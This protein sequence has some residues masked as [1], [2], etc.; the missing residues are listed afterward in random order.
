MN[1][2]KKMSFLG[3]KH[4]AVF[5][6]SGSHLHQLKHTETQK[7]KTQKK[8]TDDDDTDFRANI[9]GGESQRNCLIFSNSAA[10]FHDALL[11]SLL[12]TDNNR[13]PVLELCVNIGFIF[14]IIF[15]NISTIITK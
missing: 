11:L 5:S 12:K 14:C 10:E 15:Y 8:R 6:K 2:F 13:S 9:S 7:H 4:A 1:T 3:G